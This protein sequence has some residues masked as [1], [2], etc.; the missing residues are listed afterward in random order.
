MYSQIIV[1]YDGRDEA[2]QAAASARLI[3]ESTGG[4][5][6]LAQVIGSA[7]GTVEGEEIPELP[8]AEALMVPGRSAVRALRDLAENRHAGLI[9]VGSAR[10]AGLG[11]VLL[12]SVGQWLLKE[13]HCAVAAA[14]R[15]Y[16][17][18]AS[19]E[20]RVIAVAFDGSPE[21]HS[22]LEAAAELARRAK[23]TIRLL[24]AAATPAGEPQLAETLHAARDALPPELRAAAH[25]LHGP[26]A[27]VIADE[28]EKGVDVLFVGSRGHGPVRRAMLGS[29]SSA[30]MSLA[31]CPV[32][33]TPRTTWEDE[34]QGE[35]DEPQTL[36]VGSV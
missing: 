28:A 24:A 4:H 8:G 5:L 22:A 27:G 34:G 11:T 35:G 15:G 16:R 30:L 31:P 25:L 1:G 2:G 33:I 21:S 32:V 18:T 12:G 13:S 36:A 10:R 17:L 19:G 26:P 7:P 3:A 6:L 20:P 29:F 9:V 23:A 14:P